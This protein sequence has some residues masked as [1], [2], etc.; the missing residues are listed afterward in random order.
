[1]T[2]S[3]MSTNQVIAAGYAEAVPQHL[4]TSAQPG[5]SLGTWTSPTALGPGASYTVKVYIPHPTTAQLTHAGDDYPAQVRE[6][7]L[8]LGLPQPGG[9][10]IPTV[11]FPS[12]GSHGTASEQVSRT[13]GFPAFGSPRTPIT[14]EAGNSNSGGLE[15][16]KNSPYAHAYAL[17]QRMARAARTPYA[18]VEKVLA[19]LSG[20]N[21]FVYNQNPARSRYPLATFLVAKVGYCQQFAGEMAL[22]LRMGGVPARVA[23]GFTT[24]TYDS[25]TKRWLVSDIDAHAWVEAW[26]PHYGW[27]TFDPTPAA[28]P[29][30]GGGKTTVSEFG[31]FSTYGE[32]L[33]SRQAATPA[34]SSTAHTAIHKRSSS[35]PVLP[36][37][38]AVLLVLLAVGLVAW[39]RTGGLDSDGLIAEL[40]RAMARSGR[41][42]S[43]DV[44]LAALERRFRTSPDAAAYIR[45]LRLSRFSSGHRLPT[46]SQRR[47]LRAR[48]RA[49][50]GLGGTLRSLWALPP[51]PEHRRR[52]IEK[53]GGA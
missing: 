31:T 11:Q 8:A 16:I 30:L 33:H 23:T 6:S 18:F 51:R 21:G 45:T 3:A 50:L 42:L 47:A 14:I 20:A 44:T 25:A 40:E 36:V 1:V 35:S 24:G 32:V 38:L 15:A 41:P 26:F 37:V 48:L 13:V 19:Y 12:F 22:L 46:L 2:I 9:R 43:E 39:R 17:A 5:A 29:A 53:G 4:T 28:A 34:G 49:G 27:V 52:R 7:D 10:I